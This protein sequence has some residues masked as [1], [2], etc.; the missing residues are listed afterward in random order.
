L[1][2]L[3]RVEPGRDWA[4]AEPITALTAKADALAALAAMGTS[5]DNLQLSTPTGKYWHPGRSGRLQMG[6]KN[7]L[8][9][10]G[11][12]H[13]RVLKAL[14]IAGRVVAFE[15]W[16]E[17]LP[18]PRKG[19]QSASKSKGA[20]TL[21]GLMP[22]HRDFAF[23]VADDVAAGDLLKAARGADKALISDVSLFD[24]YVGKGIDDGQKSLAIDVTLSPSGETLT[25]ADIDAVS[26]KIV[27][28]AEKIGATLRG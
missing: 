28:A 19:K 5:V 27:K 11:E 4:G 24:I 2:G 10:F 21:S 25:D 18:A 1:A 7:I 14:G 22:V 6:P 8:A 16:P 17:N 15:V 13:P 12:L 23:I 20:L 26:A 9:D 3:R